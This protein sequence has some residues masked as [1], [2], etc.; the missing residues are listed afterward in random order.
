MVVDRGRAAAAGGLAVAGTVLDGLPR[1]GSVEPLDLGV[2]DRA[3]PGPA[4]RDPVERGAEA[5]RLPGASAGGPGH[6]GDSSTGLPRALRG[7]E[8]A[9]SGRAGVRARAAAAPF[10]SAVGS[11][12]AN[13]RR[14]IA[15]NSIS[16]STSVMTGMIFRGSTRNSSMRRTQPI[17]GAVCA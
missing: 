16:S 8:R 1:P 9:V 4:L 12:T 14:R 3:E 10:A 15:R 17:I 6:R 7:P 5:L 13:R 2:A 11:F